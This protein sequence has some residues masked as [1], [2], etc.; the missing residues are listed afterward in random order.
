MPALPIGA[1]S[2][3]RRSPSLSI[4][5]WLS[6]SANT[7]SQFR[8]RSFADTSWRRYT[9][10]KMHSHPSSCQIQLDHLPLLVCDSTMNSDAVLD[11][12]PA[13][14]SFSVSLDSGSFWFIGMDQHDEQNSADC[15]IFRRE[16]ICC[17]SNANARR[18]CILP[19]K[20]DGWHVARTPANVMVLHPKRSSRII[21]KNLNFV[22]RINSTIDIE[23]TV[24]RVI[25]M[26]SSAYRG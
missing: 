4:V 19:W 23:E 26:W 16:F 13:E 18:D 24:A 6:T 15:R 14:K 25:S 20:A 17:K 1:G 12:V 11:F 10:R 7:G 9:W 22:V 5:S 3:P 2:T 8:G 21:L